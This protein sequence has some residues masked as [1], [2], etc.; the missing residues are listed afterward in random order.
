M[1]KKILF[2]IKKVR[3]IL[4]E[5]FS[6]SHKIR[7]LIYD[8]IFPNPISGF[9]Y[10][11]IFTLLTD[12]K[13]SRIVVYPTAYEV[14]GQSLDLHN[15]HMANLIKEMPIIRKKIVDVE[16]YR[17]LKPKLF[18]CIFLCNI[19]RNFAWLQ[20]Y[21]IPFVFTLY[22]G[23][24][25]KFYDSAVDNRLKAIFST[26]LF[27]KVIVNQRIIK[28]YLIERELCPPEKIC[29]IF[30]VVIPQNSIGKL[31]FKR[32]YFNNKPNETL[33]LC[34]CA[35]K[36]TTCGEDKGYDVFIKTATELSQ[37]YDFVR[38]HVI[39]GFNS[40]VIDITA[41]EDKITFY[42]YQN[43]QNLQSLFRK[44]DI[45]ISPN[46]PF[47]LCEGC[48]DGFPLGA[49]V[50]AVLNGVVAIVSDE[51][52]E[53]QYFENLKDLIICKPNKESV[54]EHIENLIMQPN[55]IKCI[56][57]KGRQ[58]FS[59]IYSDNFQMKKRLEIIKEEIEHA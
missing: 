57:E 34:F 30:G 58:K 37:K 43:Y 19:Q 39:G 17:I 11:E 53:N 10:H 5:Y 56:S 28:D 3:K 55:K 20:Q 25:F 40:T 15:N 33:N 22:P 9:K 21:Q 48:F 46:K 38:F 27:R 49:V 6:N 23:G 16:K 44:M 29:L 54:L 41:I 31:N 8:D 13:H 24:G 14:L 51:L 1:I 26:P 36:Y 2:R 7:L 32:S 59:K 12:I 42:G 52:N 18:Y 47:V 4:K 35:A 45:I 50:E